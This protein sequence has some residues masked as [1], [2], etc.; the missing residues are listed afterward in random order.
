MDDTALSGDS[1][2]GGRGAREG[3]LG[4]G[5]PQALL[6]L[7]GWG[8]LDFRVRCP[9]TAGGVRGGGGWKR[10]GREGWLQGTPACAGGVETL[11]C[12]PWSQLGRAG[13][14]MPREDC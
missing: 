1:Q 13:V 12:P 14:G 7:E 6:G 2:V 3:E 9:S 10:E 11:L 8:M 5:V 4:S